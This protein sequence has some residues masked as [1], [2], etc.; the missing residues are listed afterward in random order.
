MYLRWKGVK[1]YS[2]YLDIFTKLFD[3]FKLFQVTKDILVISHRVLI[4]MIFHL[5]YF[6]V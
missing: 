3:D 6:S 4:V 2:K 5:T 1:Y